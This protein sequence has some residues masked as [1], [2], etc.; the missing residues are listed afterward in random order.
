MQNLAI[1][2]ESNKDA[3]YYRQQVSERGILEKID[4]L[5]NGLLMIKGV[6]EENLARIYELLNE[7]EISLNKNANDPCTR[8]A[9]QKFTYIVNEKIEEKVAGEPDQ[10]ENT[11]EDLKN[12]DT[13]N[14]K[15][16]DPDG[17]VIG[18]RGEQGEVPTGEPIGEPDPAENTEG[19]ATDTQEP[20]DETLESTE[21]KE[22]GGIMEKTEPTLETPVETPVDID[23]V[24]AP[25]K[26]GRKKKDAE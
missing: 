15:G 22:D 16:T 10:D 25:K 12:P 21:K 14:L 7:V 19:P 11:E 9:L 23:G 18:E 17:C 20:A 4:A 1:F 5:N 3:A 2:H 13:E 6:D 24:P 26:G 8:M